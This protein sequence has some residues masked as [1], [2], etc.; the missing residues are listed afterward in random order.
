[1]KGPYYHVTCLIYVEQYRVV[2]GRHKFLDVLLLLGNKTR[3]P[4]IMI[5]FLGSKNIKKLKTLH[6]IKQ[7]NY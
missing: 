3:K 1:M 4:P 5:Y 7:T 2:V 6:L